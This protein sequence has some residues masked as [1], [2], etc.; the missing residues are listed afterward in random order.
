M[1]HNSRLLICKSDAFGIISLDS[2]SAIP[3]AWLCGC[4]A[5]QPNFLERLVGHGILRALA[6]NHSACTILPRC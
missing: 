5:R 1:Q 6:S 3:M 4:Q 2:L